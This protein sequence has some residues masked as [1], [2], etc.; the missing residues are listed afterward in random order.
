MQLNDL[1]EK[2]N[3]YWK[4]IPKYFPHTTI[5]Q[6]IFMP[7]HMHGIIIINK[8][9][10]RDAIY[11]VS[12]I[13]KNNQECHRVS[14]NNKNNQTA[15]IPKEKNPMTNNSLSTIIR[16]YKGRSTFEIN[17]STNKKFQWQSR[18]YEHIIRDNQ[19]LRRVRE[20]IKNNPKEWSLNSLN[21]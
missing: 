9:A 11:G 18:F 5:D 15:I 19:D 7:D 6:Y 21:K 8:F 10:C 2:A 14:Y 20:Y 3:V 1:G 13:N 17:K 16:W 12:H 4:Q